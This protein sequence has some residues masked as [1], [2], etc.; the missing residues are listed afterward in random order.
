MLWF[1]IIGAA[2]IIYCLYKAYQ[3]HMRIKEYQKELEPS[4]EVKE[5]VIKYAKTCFD[6]EKTLNRHGFNFSQFL[7]STEKDQM[8]V[9][10]MIENN[11]KLEKDISK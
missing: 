8:R 10:D 7:H 9:L 2:C 5:H 1:Y 3:A 4:D 6:L 11:I